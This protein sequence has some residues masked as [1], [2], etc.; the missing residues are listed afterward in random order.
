[1]GFSVRQIIK[2]CV[3]DVFILAGPEDKKTVAG[4]SREELSIVTDIL[5]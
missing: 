2:L 3:A 1:M 4:P 5:T